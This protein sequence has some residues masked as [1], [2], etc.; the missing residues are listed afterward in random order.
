[1]TSPST[2]P[3][4][5]F[6]T[7]GF[8]FERELAGAGMS[9]V[10]VARE[11]A[12]G[13]R[14]VVKVLSHEVAGTMSAERFALEI[15]AAATVQHANIVPLLTTG[16]TGG[17]PWFS[18]PYIDGESLRVR[19]QR[20]PMS[21]TEAVPILRD[22]ARALDAA[23]QHGI[24]HRDIKPENILLSGGVAL[25]T[26]FGVARALRDAVAP[27][28]AFRTSQ[29]TAM[30][31]P[32]YMAPEQATADPALD[33]RA[34]LYALGIVA[35]EMLAGRHPYAGR[36]P[37]E[38][39]TDQLARP[40]PPIETV[41][42]GIPPQLARLVRQLLEKRPEARPPHARAVLDLLA[43][44]FTTGGAPAVGRVPGAAPPARIALGFLAALTVLTA[45]L[46]AWYWSAADRR[47][48]GALDEQVVAVAPFRTTGADPALQYLREGAMD[49][50]GPTLGADRELRV[51][52]AGTFLAAWRSAG[53][54]EAGEP[55]QPDMLQAARR[56]GAGQLV[57]GTVT[58]TASQLVLR[59]TIQSSAPGRLGPIAEAQVSGPQ[60]SLAVMVARLATQLLAVRAGESVERQRIFAQTPFVA[61]QHYL[62]GRAAFR[63][64]QYA[65]A[66][67]DFLAALDADTTFA[68]AGMAAHHAASWTQDPRRTALAARVWPFRGKLGLAD[69][70]ALIGW[71]GPNYPAPTMARERL[72]VREAWVQAAPG[73]PDAVYLL[74]DTYLHEGQMSDMP[75]ARGRALAAF[76][77]ALALDPSFLP[78]AEHL[79]QLYAERGDTAKARAIVERKRAAGPRNPFV[80]M[81]ELFLTPP[82]DTAA[83]RAS[84]AGL[85][86]EGTV[87]EAAQIA[88]ILAVHPPTPPTR[89]MRI[90]DAVRARVV[91][92][93]DRR[94][95]QRAAVLLSGLAGDSV[96][97]GRLLADGASV[98]PELPAEVVAMHVVG[99]APAGV[100]RAFADR[101]WAMLPP[102]PRESDAYGAWDA[103]IVALT[104]RAWHERE[105]PALARIQRWLAPHVARTPTGRL[106]RTLWLLASQ[107]EASLDGRPSRDSLAALDAE[108]VDPYFGLGF[109]HEAASWLAAQL[110][111]A[112]GDRPRAARVLGR[113]WESRSLALLGARR[114]DLARWTT[115]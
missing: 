26:D 59:A 20:G 14:V 2:L 22:V 112:A 56:V 40:I 16:T 100:A 46:G 70:L 43:E 37:A 90:L 65:D 66:T 3:P 105:R 57:T 9:R 8:E 10:Y 89:P 115:R 62:A 78:A 24:V 94:A 7:S 101:L 83:E 1:M 109:R 55:S 63:R 103:S 74:G 33:H 5:G 107:A 28:T 81:N 52:E 72:A 11:I 39:M 68:L 93:G 113:V 69:S 44:Q 61:L 76:E 35:W 91:S 19:L 27:E 38:M 102:A 17:V 106:P 73:N 25:V 99:A 29:G 31:T 64:G 95:W 97:V 47:G 41:R 30:G 58:G 96:A 98:A 49:L 88:L 21:P 51:V 18:M 77:R 15:R 54:S 23:H 48:A 104:M 79:T 87:P 86:A 6:P 84:I 80:R 85:A 71:L 92:D 67:E 111:A 114:R 4:P 34:D 108:L 50:L 110:W 75:D 36:S 53:G 42:G 45:G 32:A 13:R 82:A 60:D 12:L